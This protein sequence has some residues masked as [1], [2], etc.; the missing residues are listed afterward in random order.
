MLVGLLVPEYEPPLDLA[1]VDL[2][3]EDVEVVHQVLDPEVLLVD[4]RSV[5]AAGKT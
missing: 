2:V 4:V 3:L 5:A 1:L